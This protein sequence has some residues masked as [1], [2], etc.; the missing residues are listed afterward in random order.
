MSTMIDTTEHEH[1]LDSLRAL[2]AEREMAAAVLS[3]EPNVVYFSGIRFDPL[4]SSATRALLAVV[5]VDAP[6]HL[7]LPGFV[8]DE[9]AEHWP[10]ATVIPYDVP[11]D[12]PIPPLLDVLDRLRP[13]RVG[14]EIGAESRVGFTIGQWAEIE[15]SLSGRITDV[16]E[17]AWAL[18]TRKSQIEIESLRRAAHAAGAGFHHAYSAPLL[19]RAEQEIARS[20][21]EGAVAGGADRVGWIG[22]TSGRGSYERFVSAP[23]S[24]AVETGDMVWADVGVLSDGYWTDYCRAAVVGE[25]TSQ[26]AELQAAVVAAT[27]AG[28]DMVRP[29]NSVAEVARTIRERAS[30]VGLP[31]IGYGRLG[32]GIGLSA[33]EPPSVAEWD[34][35]V[36]EEGM[37]VTIEPAL[38]HETGLYC[39]EQVVA[40]GKLGPDL[41]SI[42]PTELWAT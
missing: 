41:L 20:I 17:S 25:V 18:R 38:V 29:G 40:V 31:L 42:A 23:R 21:S 32:H 36:L 16:Q 19:G 4:W 11:P 10:D 24:R 2:L 14:F 30:E 34:T 15:S 9:A 37:V 33:T 8:A 1:R 39:T 12:S 35:T 26:R 7:I 28:V 3:S 22:M 27:Q 13:G 5:P 6:L